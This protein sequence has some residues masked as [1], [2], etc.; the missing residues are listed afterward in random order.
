MFRQYTTFDT[1]DE[2]LHRVVHRALRCRRRHLEWSAQHRSCSARLPR[3]PTA[4]P[5]PKRT[6][7]PRRGPRASEIHST[8]STASV[9]Q[10]GG[11]GE[12]G[13]GEGGGEDGGGSAGGGGV[14][15]GGTGGGGAGGGGVGGG[16]VGGGGGGAGLEN[17]AWLAMG[18]TRQMTST[19]V[20]QWRLRR[21]VAWIPM[22]GN[23]VLVWCWHPLFHA[24]RCSDPRHDKQELLTQNLLGPYR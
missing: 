17:I 6:P 24:S 20:I 10:F 21:G 22:A 14:G 4:R 8:S 19:S 7:K 1:I 12:G 18:G 11:G 15:G 2:S 5:R 13:G 3:M 23:K 16:G 9:T